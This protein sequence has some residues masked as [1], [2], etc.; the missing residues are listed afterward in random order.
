MGVGRQVRRDIVCQE[1]ES[2]RQVTEEVGMKTLNLLH[3]EQNNKIKA[4]IVTEK[5][6]SRRCILLANTNTK[7]VEGYKACPGCQGASGSD[8]S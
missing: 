2:D 4:N 5:E 7:C 1:K 6:K 3:V 8:H